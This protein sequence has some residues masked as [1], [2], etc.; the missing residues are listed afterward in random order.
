MKDRSTSPAGRAVGSRVPSSYRDDVAQPSRLRVRVA[1][2]HQFNSVRCNGP[3]LLVATLN[4][5]ASV[6][7]SHERRSV[8]TFLGLVGRAVC[9]RSSISAPRTW[10]GGKPDWCIH[11]P[12]H[13]HNVF[14]QWP[15]AKSPLGEGQGEGQRTTH[16][17][18]QSRRITNA[19][20]SGVRSLQRRFPAIAIAT[21]T[22]PCAPPANDALR[23]P[24]PRQRSAGR[25][26]G[27]GVSELYAS[28]YP[29]TQSRRITNAPA[30]WS[31][32]CWPTAK[33]SAR[34]SCIATTTSIPPSAP[35]A[36]DALRFPLS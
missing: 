22:P 29:S 33:S 5:G 7:A 30:S 32:A 14:P 25:G 13:V 28:R 11:Q 8:L 10:L 31:A 17:T 23:F 12:T 9:R 20:A 4:G 6:L 16:R 34:F 18:N 1:S 19:P 21:S 35:P 15:T 36:N 3:M 26:P 27:R 2:R 24:S